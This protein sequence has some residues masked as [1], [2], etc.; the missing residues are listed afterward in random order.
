[1]RRGYTN[2]HGH[3]GVPQQAFKPTIHTSGVHKPEDECSRGL[4]APR[5]GIKHLKNVC[6]GEGW[7]ATYLLCNVLYLGG[8]D[9]NKL[10][11]AQPSYLPRVGNVTIIGVS[12][13]QEYG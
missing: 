2:K 8:F 13:Q 10:P 9:H 1:M 7:E 3:S 5:V 4:L 12:H 6:R 11:T